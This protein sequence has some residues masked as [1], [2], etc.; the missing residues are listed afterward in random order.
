MGNRKHVCSL[1][2]ACRPVVCKFCNRGTKNSNATPLPVAK[3]YSKFL[4][5]LLM[6]IHLRQYSGKYRREKCKAPEKLVGVI[7]KAQE[8]RRDSTL[9]IAFLIKEDTVCVERQCNIRCDSLGGGHTF[10]VKGK[11]IN[12]LC[13]VGN[14]AFVAVI[15]LLPLQAQKESLTQMST[16]PLF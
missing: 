10:S 12:I 15:Q 8:A 6:R 14:A 13:F 2:M 5:Q 7:N 9:I 11:I 4:F 3:K 16:V 1:Y